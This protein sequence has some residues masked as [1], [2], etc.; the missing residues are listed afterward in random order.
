MRNTISYIN[1]QLYNTLVA[2]KEILGGCSQEISNCLDNAINKLNAPIQL[3]I[4]GKISSSKSTL[5]NA[6][7]GASDIVATGKAEL[8]YNV[9]W[10]KYGSLDDDIKIVFKDGTYD[11]KPR[12]EWT[13]L[14]NRLSD[15][16]AIENEE[17]KQYI[18]KIK[19]IEEKWVNNV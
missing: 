10:L 8:T 15:E 5:V 18:D 11:I 6:I 9:N 14:A 19:Y 1:E 12:K 4:I 13:R 17:L 16:E 2:S 7:L 3:A